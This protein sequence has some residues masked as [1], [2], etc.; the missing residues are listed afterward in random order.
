M[1]RIWGSGSRRD[2]RR[3]RRRT[4][5]GDRRGGTASSRRRGERG[6]R[7]RGIVDPEG[8]PCGAPAGQ[9]RDLRVVRVRDHDRVLRELCDRGAPPRRDRLELAV[10]VELVAEEVAEAERPRPHCSAT[11]GSA[12][13]STSSSARSAPRASSNVDATPETR[14]APEVL[15]ASANRGARISAAIFAVVVLPFVAETSTAPWGSRA[16]EPLERAPVELEQQLSGHR[17]PA[18]AAGQARQAGRGASRSDLGREGEESPCATRYPRR[19]FPSV[20]GIFPASPRRGR[21][22]PGARRGWDR[23]IAGVPDAARA[24]GAESEERRCGSNGREVG[25]GIAEIFRLQLRHYDIP[26]R[27]GGEEFAILLPETPPDQAFEIAERRR[28]ADRAGARRA[29]PRLRQPVLPA[30]RRGSAA[31]PRRRRQRRRAAADREA[32]GRLV[33]ARRRARGARDT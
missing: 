33:G 1:R 16:A 26:A 27:F 5:R 28:A 13:S 2:G 15:C 4:R 17:R 25:E 24:D 29:A 12:F 19:P 23:R 9:L 18:A 3:R 8:E 11:P 6:Q 30:L 20:R 7:L 31:H 22:S 32:D 14:F 21:V 10:A